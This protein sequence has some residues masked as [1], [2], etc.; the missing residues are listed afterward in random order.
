MANAIA[1]WASAEQQC[2]QFFLDQ[3]QA[4]ENVDGY[5]GEFPHTHDAGSDAQ[6]WMF[7]V[8]GGSDIT[9]IAASA[10][11]YG[12]WRMDAAIRG[13]FTKRETAQTVAG[14]ALN[15]LPVDAGTL[16]SVSRLT[17]TAM[18]SLERASIELGNDQTRG[19]PVRVW[20]LFLPLMVL[21]GNSEYGGG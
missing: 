1:S 18:P 5:L 15:A 12:C 8:N 11:P 17:H 16:D 13:I 3:L 20:A 19:G 4:V 7:E 21:F 14:M 9:Q 2:F 6:M 10:K